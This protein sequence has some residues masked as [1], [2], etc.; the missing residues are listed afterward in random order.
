MNRGCIHEHI[1]V[2]AGVPLV[3]GINFQG[4][5]TVEARDAD[6]TTWLP[7]CPDDAYSLRSCAGSEAFPGMSPSAFERGL[8]GPRG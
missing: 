1:E 8:C 2:K 3:M 7:V 4:L 6:L 5:A